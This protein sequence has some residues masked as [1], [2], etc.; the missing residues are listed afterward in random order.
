VYYTGLAGFSQWLASDPNGQPLAQQLTA[1]YGDSC[2]LPTD[3]A[4]SALMAPQVAGVLSGAIAQLPAAAQRE[5]RASVNAQ[6]NQAVAGAKPLNIGLLEL[7]AT[8]LE[9]GQTCLYFGQTTLEGGTLL[10]VLAGAA[11]IVG[12]V[13]FHGRKKS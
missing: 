10:L 13:L 12:L 4:N 9:L 1:T 3:A 2:N 7:G 11:L 5:A 8:R 6:L